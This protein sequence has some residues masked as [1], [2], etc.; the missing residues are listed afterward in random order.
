[1]ETQF[2]FLIVGLG[3]PGDK[4]VSTRHNLGFAVVDALSDRWGAKSPQ[5]KFQGIIS[6]STHENGRVLLLKPQT[7]MNLSGES[8]REAAQFYKL[9]PASQMIV[10]TDDLD[11]PAGQL[12]LRLHGGS[13]GHN[14]LKSIT[15]CLGTEKYAR[16]RMGIGR[17]PEIPAESYVL[18]K[19]P[20]SEAALYEDAV[21]QAISGIE[22]IL[23]V[24]LEKSM[25]FINQKRNP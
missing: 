15:E 16:L 14:G 12:R 7:Y 10:I 9:E 3:N 20:K 24:G 17:S 2:P 19:I 8:V 23:K 1:M 5:K 21:I 13:G 4:Y 18:M 22:E 25:N 11:L 6:E